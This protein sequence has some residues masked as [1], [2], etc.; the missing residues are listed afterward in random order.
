MSLDNSL[1]E[2][3][4]LINNHFVQRVGSNLENGRDHFIQ[5]FLRFAPHLSKTP[6]PF[7]EIIQVVPLLL[8]QLTLDP[9]YS[10]YAPFHWKTT[11]PLEF[12]SIR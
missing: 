2:Y 7:A 1:H 5:M 11:H 4:G 6:N 12:S 9:G 10:S 3:L 8:P